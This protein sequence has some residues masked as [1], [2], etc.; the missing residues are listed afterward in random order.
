MSDVERIVNTNAERVQWAREVERMTQ[1]K[2]NAAPK[3]PAR[4]ARSNERFRA[5][6]A[7]ALA[8][9]AASGAGAAFAGIG[10]AAD[11]PLTVGFGLLVVAVFVSTGARLDAYA[12]NI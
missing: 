8:C 5:I 10:M 12:R 11:Q 9:A 7:A 1:E 3:A 6:R 2:T 4:K